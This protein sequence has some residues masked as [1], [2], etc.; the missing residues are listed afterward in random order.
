M[1]LVHLFS[2]DSSYGRPTDAIHHLWEKLD[3]ALNEG[4]APPVLLRS[5]VGSKEIHRRIVA[6][7]WPRNRYFPTA[8]PV[9]DDADLCLLQPSDAPAPPKKVRQKRKA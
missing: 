7:L 1:Q 6:N 9:V 8:L 2:S 3:E 4:A 5:W